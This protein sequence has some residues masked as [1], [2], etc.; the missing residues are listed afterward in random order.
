MAASRARRS[1]LCGVNDALA[2]VQ[3][4]SS[5]ILGGLWYHNVPA[6]FA[7]AIVRA[8]I[9]GLT[10]MTAPPA[11]YGP[12]LL[13][14]AGLVKTIYA[15]YI[16]FEH[17][18]LAPNFRKAA[19]QGT[20]EVVDCDEAVLVGGLMATVEGLPFH[21]LSSL[22]GTRLLEDSPLIL[23][24]PL[25]DGTSGVAAREI[26]PE[27]AVIHA[28]AADEFG[29][30]RHEGSVFADLLLAKAAERVIVT[31]DEVISH[32]EIEREPHRTS[33]PAYLVDAVVEMPFGAHPCSSHGNYVQDEA[34][35]RDYLAAASATAKGRDPDAWRR[36]LDRYVADPADNYEYLDRVG[37]LRRLVELRRGAV[38]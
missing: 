35:L 34:H 15:A 28:Q 26:R 29:N 23:R 22:R 2:M 17:L 19:E 9:G 6:A 20:V 7:R 14:G 18:G 33:I 21:P 24:L 5:V 25:P 1:K 30:V 16:G 8:E 11:G 13:I 3:P 36:Y 12:D 4:N 32:R 37:G 27:V 38:Q 10:V 31:V